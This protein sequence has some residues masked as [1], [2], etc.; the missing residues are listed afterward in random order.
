M[1]LDDDLRAEFGAGMTRHW[2][3]SRARPPATVSPRWKLEY[4]PARGVTIVAMT[5]F[6]ATT[7]SLAARALRAA[8]ALAATW[9][10]LAAPLAAAMPVVASAPP[11]STGVDAQPS[12]GGAC[13]LVAAASCERDDMSMGCCDAGGQE[14]RP[15]EAAST[16]SGPELAPPAASSLVAAVAPLPDG[17]AAGATG[18]QPPPAGT[19]LYT[20]HSSL[21]N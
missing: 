2:V 13:P 18:R 7:R 15:G 5:G 19:P 4:W 10:L 3:N 9:F 6:H 8:M 20:L 14:Q 1:R 11:G 12:C 16:A 21:L 17:L